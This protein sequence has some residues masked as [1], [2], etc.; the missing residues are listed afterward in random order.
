MPNPG[1]HSPAASG[2]RAVHGI[3]SVELAAQVQYAKGV[4][5]KRAALLAKLGI[6]TVRDAL[7]YFPFRYEDRGNFRKVAHLTYGQYET[8]M[9]EVMDARV[10][11]TARRRMKIFEL[12]VRDDTGVVTG[13][14]FNQPFMQRAFSVGQKV[15]LSGIP[16]P[17][18]YHGF[19]AVMESPEY[20]VIE[21]D[22]ERTIHT[23]RI[24]PIYRTTA[25]ISVRAIRSVMKGLVDGHAGALSEFLPEGFH[26][27]FRIPAL[28]D[29]VREVHFPETE[30]DV[31]VLNARAS[32]AHKRLI[33]DE[34]F[35]LQLGLALLK[36]GR[37][38]ESD[39]IS[40]KGDGSLT[41]RLVKGLPFRLTAAQAR[42]MAEV[43]SDM[44]RP[45]PMSRLLQGDV[46]C[47][48][49]VVAVAAIL[50]AAESGYQSALMA[51]TEIL[52]EQHYLG[53]K[54]YFE[55]LG[56]E[57][58]LLTSSQKKKEKDAALKEIAEG[59]AT[60]AV[61]THA[62]IQGGV[63][64][65]RLGLVV[66][67]EQHRFGVAQ[68]AVLK[69]K[70]ANPDVLVMTAT[71]IPRTL[72]L[73]VYGDLDVSVIDEMPAG[74]SPVMTRLFD[75]SARAEAYR[76]IKKEVE[77]GRQAYVV[78]PLIEESEKSDL[79]AA[80]EGGERLGREQGPGHDRLPGGRY[81]SPRRDDGG[82]GRRGRPE[83]DSDAHRARGAVRA[84][85]A[86]P[87]PG[88]GR[89]LVAPVVLRAPRVQPE[90]GFG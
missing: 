47:G 35:L 31:A 51:P 46:G 75:E 37:V 86:P 90:H 38:V 84:R 45:K 70:G 62:L 15:V 32:R 66:V 18:S 33:F 60:L 74:R 50:R 40:M 29:A 42:V 17:D 77:K 55:P 12:A 25:G 7:Y 23:G 64:F 48:K 41:G 69:G 9:G 73:T 14:W 57:V 5:P 8:V 1:P 52:A 30:K 21:D 88:T 10:V 67:D 68:R 22:E 24:V 87:A 65:G 89:P 59:R 72:A 53:L 80:T 81:K 34:F 61:G 76:L 36:R 44:A 13:V 54:A 6:V 85:P 20:E 39:G 71:P 27:R 2:P 79:K 28:P 19:R 11:T 58:A 63:A 49:T 56:L 82:G 83:R 78:F 16:K 26:E 3:N 4:G 43:A